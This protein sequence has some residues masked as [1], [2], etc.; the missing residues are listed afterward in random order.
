MFDQL[1]SFANEASVISE[2]LPPLIKAGAVAL[3]GMIA[4]GPIMLVSWVVAWASTPAVTRA[5]KKIAAGIELLSERSAE[6]FHNV[7]VAMDQLNS[8]KSYVSLEEVEHIGRPQELENLDVWTQ[9]LRSQLEAAPLIAANSEQEKQNTLERLN[10]ALENLAR[11]RDLV[12]TPRIP[13][14]SSDDATAK[15]KKREAL[16]AL[17]VFTPLTIVAIII[18]TALLDVFFADIF[19]RKEVFDIAY[20]IIISFVFS[21]IEAGVGIVLGFLAT[22]DLNNRGSVITTAICWTVILSLV[23][24]EAAL[25]FLVGTNVIGNLDLD[26]ASLMITNGE[27]VN[28]FLMGAWFALIGPAIVLSLYLFGHNLAEAYFKFT[29]FTSFEQFRKSM[30][31][32]YETSQKFLSDV[33]EGESTVDELLKRLSESEFA[34]NQN[35]NELPERVSEYA[36]I[37]GKEVDAVNDA[38]ES[39]KALI[40]QPA[41]A[42]IHEV[43]AEQTSNIL[44]I[45]SVFLLLLVLAVTIGAWTFSTETLPFI[46][47]QTGGPIVLSIFVSLISLSAG[48]MLSPKASLVA[49]TEVG[50]ASVLIEKRSVTMIV[51]VAV[52]SVGLAAFYWFVFAGA[53]LPGLR[54]SLAVALNIACFF[55]G[56]KLMASFTA[57]LSISTII[58]NGVVSLLCRLLIWILAAVSGALWLALSLLNI[59]AAPVERLFVLPI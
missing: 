24:I 44:R 2:W 8:Q 55:V 45:S 49:A 13:K 50:P 26:D 37:L 31:K 17:M 12:R 38:V 46:T 6:F 59:F 28:L 36:T 15:L 41:K 1:L 20:S 19:G 22:K 43:G 3:I 23:L 9:S 47:N 25:Y 40:V 51:S 21:V 10:G 5:T 48:Y 57:W 29:R 11:A 14:V 39:A 54:A 56:T 30:D 4:L 32:G 52:G 58:G 33:K 42:V 16:T 18:N 35:K 34:L 27:I 53:T 7:S